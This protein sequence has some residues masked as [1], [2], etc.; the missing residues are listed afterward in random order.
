METIEIYGR[1]KDSS[2]TPVEKA[3]ITLMIGNDILNIC[4][5]D[6]EGKFDHKVVKDPHFLGSELTYIV[7]KEG[8]RPETKSTKIEGTKVVLGDIELTKDIQSSPFI[9]ISGDIKDAEGRSIADAKVSFFFGSGEPVILRTDVKGEFRHEAKKEQ[10]G[11]E[12]KYK[13]EKDGYNPKEGS[14]NVQEAGTSL[15]ITMDP[16]PPAPPQKQVEKKPDDKKPTNLILAGVAV[17]VILIIAAWLV[18]PKGVVTI[19]EFEA[20]QNIIGIHE[21]TNLTWKTSNAESVFINDEK[22][23]TLS[24]IKEVD[25]NQSTKYTLTAQNGTKKLKRN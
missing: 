24:G 9:I 16:I 17:A 22:V 23:P 4:I 14:A 1:V 13:A 21:K 3:N 20:S 19:D 2:G 5:S 15:A 18:W 6:S 25:P 8:Y 7:K 11:M 12:F 10:A